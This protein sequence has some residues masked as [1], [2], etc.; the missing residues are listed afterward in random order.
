MALE[1]TMTRKELDV[2]EEYQS[3]E[4]HVAPREFSMFCTGVY[5]SDL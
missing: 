1:E 4:R 2:W 3:E 5:G